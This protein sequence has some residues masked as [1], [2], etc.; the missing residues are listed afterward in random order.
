MKTKRNAAFAAI[1]GCCLLSGGCATAERWEN[2][3][4]PGELISA[5]EAEKSVKAYEVYMEYFIRRAYV[6]DERPLIPD[7]PRVVHAA[8]GFIDEKCDVYLDNLLVADKGSS[9]LQALL[10]LAG[11]TT[12]AIVSVLDASS[13]T[14]EALVLGF[15]F[16]SSAIKIASHSYLFGVGATV[17]RAHVVKTRLAYRTDNLTAINAVTT[18]PEIDY[19]IRDYM[20]L[21]FPATIEAHFTKLIVTAD[22]HVGNDGEMKVV[23]PPALAEEIEAEVAP[24]KIQ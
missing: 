14:F 23:T 2:R 3:W 17:V 24:K 12:T 19:V 13:S 7:K 22:A 1:A 21:C 11:T 10:T 18:D 8:M 5:K 6:I 4:G 16:T 15:G 9:G 20:S